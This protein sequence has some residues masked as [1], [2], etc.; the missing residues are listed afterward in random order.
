ML[1]TPFDA[2]GAPDTESLSRLVDHVTASG[3]HGVSAFGLAAEAHALSSA[4]RQRL[5]ELILE[6]VAGRIP[7][8][9]TV[10]AESTALACS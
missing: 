5:A 6:R 3:A 7:V 10:T 4:E 1:A 9:I 8:V 2:D